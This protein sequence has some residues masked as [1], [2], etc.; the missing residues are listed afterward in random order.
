MELKGVEVS[1]HAAK[2]EYRFR[3]KGRILEN[4]Q[5]DLGGGRVVSIDALRGFD[6][7]WIIGGGELFASLAEVWKHPVTQTIQCQLGHVEWEGFHF[8]DLIFPLFLFVVGVV[9]PFSVS[10]RLERG[11]SLGAVYLHVVK[12][13]V[14]LILLGL[15]MNGLLR[16]DWPQMRWPGVLQRIGLCYFF[17]A[18]LVI[19]TKWRTQAVVAAA[20]LLL[21]WAVMMLI[22]V[23]GHGMGVLT[24]KG[25]LSSYIDQQLI[26]GTLYYVYG[27]NEG[28]ISTL[29]AVCTALLGVLAGHWLGSNRSGARKA[30][31]LTVAGLVCL[32]T[33]YVWGLFFP[34]IKII[35]TSSYVLY[36]GGWSLLLLALFYWLIDV[37]GYKKWA[38][39]FVIIGMNPITIYFL[40]SF[41]S[42]DGIAEFFLVGISE[43]AG[44]FKPLVLAFG[45]LTVKWLFLWFLYRRRIFF[46]I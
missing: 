35:W 45:A 32:I 5:K 46:R 28:L 40:Q 12:R 20:I 7:F 36:A 23:P 21:Y 31:G 37:K 4:D 44:L 34:I 2:G 13:T 16:F 30:A 10:R 25:C 15:V 26:P 43:R 14:M 22:P 17:A 38:L 29:P 42:F 27:D 24:A 19:H 8:E 39:F 6:M 11:Q 9:L 3:E 18:I 41:V 33:G 1:L